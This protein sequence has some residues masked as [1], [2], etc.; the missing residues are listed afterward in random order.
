MASLMTFAYL[1][2]TSWVRP[3]TE[4]SSILFLD[5]F[6][7]AD[8]SLILPC[9]QGW[10]RMPIAHMHSRGR[11][12]GSRL[13]AGLTFWVLSDQLL[14]L[15]ESNPSVCKFSHLSFVWIIHGAPSLIKPRAQNICT[16]SMEKFTTKNRQPTHQPFSFGVSL[17]FQAFVKL[18]GETYFPW[19]TLG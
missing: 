18:M 4:I 5:V 15:T 14:D 13:T 6:D 9:N 1:D 7:Q 8:S 19:V 12:T 11:T 17:Y 3:L 10:A 2:T 16:V